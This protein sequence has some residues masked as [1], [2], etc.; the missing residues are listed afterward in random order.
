MD[1]EKIML[2]REE[3]FVGVAAVV[4]PSVV[5]EDAEVGGEVRG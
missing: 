5:E 4:A 1:F 2:C 3:G